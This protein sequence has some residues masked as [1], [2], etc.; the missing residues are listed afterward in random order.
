MFASNSQNSDLM[1]FVGPEGL[2][3]LVV[4]GKKATVELKARF[5]KGEVSA[6]GLVGK[7]KEIVP[8]WEPGKELMGE[9]RRAEAAIRGAEGS[10]EG[11][12]QGAGNAPGRVGFLQRLSNRFK[13]LVQGNRREVRQAGGAGQEDGGISGAIERGRHA[14]RSAEAA[15]RSAEAA[16]RSAEAAVR[17]A[18]AAVRS[19][20]A[21]VG[22]VDDKISFLRTENEGLVKQRPGLQDEIRVAGDRAGFYQKRAD[23]V[24]KRIEGLLQDLN[25]VEERIV[26]W[27]SSVYQNEVAPSLRLTP[28]WKSGSRMSLRSLLADWRAEVSGGLDPAYAPYPFNFNNPPKMGNIFDSIVESRAPPELIGELLNVLGEG[29]GRV[30][31]VSVR[32]SAEMAEGFVK[33]ATVERP[34]GVVGDRLTKDARHGQ[35]VY[36]TQRVGTGIK[37]LEF[38]Q[39]VGTHYNEYD[40]DFNKARVLDLTDPRVVGRFNPEYGDDYKLTAKSAQQARMAGYDVVMYE[41]KRDSGALNFAVI[42][43]HNDLIK[44]DPTV[45]PV[46]PTDRTPT[47]AVSNP[48]IPTPSTAH[49]HP[50]PPLQLEPPTRAGPQAQ[51]SMQVFQPKVKPEPIVYEGAVYRYEKST[52]EKTTWTIH[53]ANIRANHRYSEPGKGAVYGGTSPE[54]AKAEI[55]H[56]N[57]ASGR[58]LMSKQVK[59]DRVLD[60]TSP[61]VR[62]KLGISLDSIAGNDYNLT[63]NI[64]NWARQ[65]GY[66]GI[67]APSA[68]SGVGSNLIVFED[69]K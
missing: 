51:S 45:H 15:V 41:S 3:S 56:Y 63:H 67:L 49:P 68:R 4:I 43:R 20:E 39:R 31:L 13:E 1:S 16:V 29:D 44:V 34:S 52:R 42:E 14:V 65:N 53:E 11:L 46:T 36:L 59:I 32:S 28:E 69:L 22:F 23:K 40:V 50:T 35:A 33:T 38:H 8:G 30:R 60:L 37:E 66:Q 7:I 61:V 25:S 17:S 6:D 55:D 19:A 12:A 2:K 21:A 27:D 18:E 48:N 26:N 62:Q 58:V 24:G 5:S 54:T 64:G 57:A 9:L 10:G 47:T